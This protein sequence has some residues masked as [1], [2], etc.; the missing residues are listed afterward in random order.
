MRELLF[1]AAVAGL[2]SGVSAD[3]FEVRIFDNDFSMNPEGG[4]IVDPV[5]KLGD[6]VRW[7]WDE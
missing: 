1:A 2:C 5:I 3:I 4:P 7:I 6:T